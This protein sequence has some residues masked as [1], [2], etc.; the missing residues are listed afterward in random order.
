MKRGEIWWVSFDAAQKGEIQKRRPAIIISN[1]ASN[2]HLN[3]LQIVPVTS[4]IKKVFPG[5]TIVTIN[6]KNHKAV[7]N[8]LTSASKTRL[9]R[10]IGRLT[11]HDLIKV[12]KAV[13][14]QLDL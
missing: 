5:E 13:R 12:E 7:A 9:S 10:L 11:V 14:V 1:D 4:N 6:N 3:R 8:Q 2:R